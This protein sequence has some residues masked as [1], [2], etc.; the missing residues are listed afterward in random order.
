ML[1]AQ[2]TDAARPRDNSKNINPAARERADGWRTMT[3]AKASATTQRESRASANP[4]LVEQESPDGVELEVSRRA[5]RRS[6]SPSD[7][8]TGSR[9]PRR[10]AVVDVCPSCVGRAG[11]G[12]LEVVCAC[13]ISRSILG[14]QNP[15]S[16]AFA[17]AAECRL[18]EGRGRGV[19]GRPTPL[20][21][22]ATVAREPEKGACRPVK[23]GTVLREAL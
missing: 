11:I 17:A 23:S 7:S 4:E 1:F 8:S 6:R 19:V 10:R 12:R 15:P 22:S 21:R 9:L 20:H 3:G 16:F 18:D 5:W 2:E 13:R 14:S